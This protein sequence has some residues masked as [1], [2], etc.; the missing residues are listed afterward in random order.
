M[1]ISDLTLRAGIKQLVRQ[2][3]SEQTVYVGINN[4]TKQNWNDDSLQEEFLFLAKMA[5]T[6]SSGYSTVTLF[7]RLRG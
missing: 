3:L 2:F 4:C 7:A 6:E 5:A 1:R